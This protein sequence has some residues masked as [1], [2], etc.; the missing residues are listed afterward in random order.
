MKAR[1]WP[2][3]GVGPATTSGS[4]AL[5]DTSVSLRGDGS[6]SV[7]ESPGESPAEGARLATVPV[8]DETEDVV[9]EGRHALEAAVAQD[10]SLQDA[11]PDLNLVD[12]RR[13]QRGVDKVEAVTVLLVEPGFRSIGAGMRMTS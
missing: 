11:E 13:M 3:R 5:R 9:S 7:D 1:Y 6:A 12:P 8:P 2:C 10:A 4:A